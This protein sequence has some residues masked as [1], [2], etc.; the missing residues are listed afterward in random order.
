MFCTTDQFLPFNHDE[1]SPCHMHALSFVALILIFIHIIII[2]IIKHYILYLNLRNNL[3]NCK[4]KADRAP[5]M[6]EGK[7][8]EV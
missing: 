3:C 2:I 8:V 6:R 5:G 1:I 7:V 4:R